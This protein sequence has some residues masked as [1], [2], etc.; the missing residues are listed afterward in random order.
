MVLV[1]PPVREAA[2]VAPAGAMW[3]SLFTSAPLAATTAQ[4][5]GR[6]A[7]SDVDCGTVPFSA[8]VEW[9]VVCAV[10]ENTS[11]GVTGSLLWPDSP[12]SGARPLYGRALSEPGTGLWRVRPQ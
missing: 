12:E 10:P 8:A 6:L 9:R 1:R 7:W 5:G 3:P 2:G 4:P 11:E